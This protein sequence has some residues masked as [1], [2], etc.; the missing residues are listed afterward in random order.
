[1]EKIIKGNRATRE[2]NERAYFTNMS[3]VSQTDG[4]KE[5]RALQREFDQSTDFNRYFFESDTMRAGNNYLRTKEEFQRMEA[6]INAK[7]P[8]PYE[9]PKSSAESSESS[10]TDLYR[11]SREQS[12]QNP[13]VQQYNSPD[14]EVRLLEQNSAKPSVTGYDN[15]GSGSYPAEVEQGVKRERS[16]SYS[17]SS[18]DNHLD[19]KQKTNPEGAASPSGASPAPQ[20]T[21]DS[22]SHKEKRDSSDKGKGEKE[23][24]DS[25]SD[26]KGG[27]GGKGGGS[28]SGGGG[29]DS[30]GGQ[31]GEISDS[32]S[33]EKQNTKGDVKSLIDSELEESSLRSGLL[34]DSELNPCETGLL[35][36]SYSDSSSSSD[37][38][39]K[40]KT[41][42]K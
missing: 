18:S 1:M 6:D 25:D 37:N 20:E 15:K 24:S 29:S 13:S 9:T 19:K 8:A 38:D 5:R 14:D 36:D 4:G 21:S 26:A 28:D 17:D 31:G 23:K 32:Y 7:Y 33:N 42:H 22:D 3:A 16:D 40:Q 39:E 2:E 30:A 41:E 12:Y 34:G 27:K 11:D 10:S 35:G